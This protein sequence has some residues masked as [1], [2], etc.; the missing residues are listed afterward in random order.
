MPHFP[1]SLVMVIINAAYSVAL[2]ISPQD[3]DG[4]PRSVQLP[5]HVMSHV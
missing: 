3:L 1:L 5:K 4:L 2:D